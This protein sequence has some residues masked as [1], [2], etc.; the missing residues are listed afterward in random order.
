MVTLQDKSKIIHLYEFR[1]LEE[2]MS[3]PIFE[4]VTQQARKRAEAE[5][6]DN[7]QMSINEVRKIL[8]VG[9]D[10]VNKLIAE[11]KL[12][13]NADGMIPYSSVLEYTNAGRQK[14]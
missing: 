12:W 3:S 1:T 9:Y 13:V 2:F 5:I 6:A 8:A 10:T 4:A 14:K 7:R 11:G